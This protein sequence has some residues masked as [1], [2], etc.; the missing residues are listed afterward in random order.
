MK[1]IISFIF[2]CVTLFASIAPIKSD[3]KSCFNKNSP[4]LVKFRGS[5]AIAVSSDRVLFFSK[6]YQRGYIKRDP[7][8]GLYLFRYKKRLK[9]IKFYPFNQVRDDV[10]IIGK[11]RFAKAK[12]VSL[13]NGLDSFAKMNKNI[14][15]NRLVSCVC[16]RA[17][18]LSIGGRSFIDSDFILRFL[19]KKR[20]TYGDIGLKFIQRGSGIFVKE[21]NPFFK[22]LQLRKGDKIILVDG[23]R[24]KSVSNLSK[25][26]LFLKPG[27][28]IKIVYQ[29]G[30][31]RY[32]QIVKVKRKLYGGLIKQSYLRYIG[33]IVGHDLKI[34][35]V[36]KNSLAYKLALKKGD[37]LLKIN[38]KYINSYKDIKKALLSIKTKEIYLLFS[39]DDFQF[40]V[41]FRR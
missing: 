20:V 34:D 6:R 19:D 8:L 12:I 16:C 18:G 33:L 17:F 25:Y 38:D 11:D 26:I 27:K 22:Y 1:I 5:Y 36:V 4:S 40:F 41:H 9:A 37:K 24:Y 23:K 3:F 39:R 13:S 15:V 35:R 30:K 28:L 31:H 29:R 2:F 14:K 32:K 10:G 21:R 7:F